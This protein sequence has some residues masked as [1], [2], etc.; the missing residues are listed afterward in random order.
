M[1]HIE[2]IKELRE[3]LLQILLTQTVA[4][5]TKG[6]QT[7]LPRVEYD[8][9]QVLCW[10]PDQSTLYVFYFNYVPIYLFFF[11]LD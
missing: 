10:L 1:T 11:F 4:T 2:D 9:Q 5:I 3:A 7:L 6:A 8:A